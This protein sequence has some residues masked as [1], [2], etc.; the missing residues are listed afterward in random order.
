MSNADDFVY[1]SG[2]DWNALYKDGVLAHE[3]HSS[4]DHEYLFILQIPSVEASLDWLM[5]EGR[6]PQELKDVVLI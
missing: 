5:E 3:G 4:I 6:Y 2:D 1:V